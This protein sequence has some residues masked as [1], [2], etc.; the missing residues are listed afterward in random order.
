MSAQTAKKKRL[1]SRRR[2]ANQKETSKAHELHGTGS[3]SVAECQMLE[4]DNESLTALSNPDDPQP[5]TKYP[6]LPELMNRKLGSRRKN[7]GQHVDDSEFHET[8]EEVVKN[9]VG[10]EGQSEK[11][12]ELSKRDGHDISATHSSL[13]ITR[14]HS[15]AVQK[16]ITANTA[17]EVLEKIMSHQNSD[18]SESQQLFRVCPATE[19][20]MDEDTEPLG[21]DGT[22]QRN[23]AMSEPHIQV[24]VKGISTT[25]A[26]TTDETTTECIIEEPTEELPAHVN[27]NEL[28]SQQFDSQAHN[29]SFKIENT[30]N[31]NF[32]FS[33]NRRKLGS[34]RNKEQ[35]H[36]QDSVSESY[37]TKE[38][39]AR[40]VSNNAIETTIPLLLESENDEER[41]ADTDLLKR[42]G[43]LQAN[44]SE[45]DKSKEL[46]REDISYAAAFPTMPLAL[47]VR[48]QEDRE[49]DVFMS[50]TFDHNLKTAYNYS[51][52]FQ[53]L[54]RKTRTDELDGLHQKSIDDPASM[55]ELSDP[56]DEQD[57]SPLKESNMETSDQTN[58][59]DHLNDTETLQT[60]DTGRANTGLDQ[61]Y[62]N[63]AQ[64][65]H[66]IKPT[67]EQTD[68]W[69]K[70]GLL[71]EIEESKS[72]QTLPSETDAPSDSDLQDGS[73]KTEEQNDSN[74]KPLGNR[75]KLGSS[76]RNKGRQHVKGSVAESENTQDNK[77]L[78]TT[79]MALTTDEAVQETSMEIRPEGEV[80]FDHSQTEVSDQDK[81][82]VRDPELTTIS[83]Y[84][85]VEVDQQ[86]INKPNRTQTPDEELTTAF[87]GMDTEN[88]EPDE[89]TDLSRHANNEVPQL[90][91][92]SEGIECSI[93]QE[94]STERSSH[95]QNTD[96]EDRVDQ[97]TV[98]PPKEES[99]TNEEQNDHFR[100]SDVRGAQLSED[101]VKKVLEEEDIKQTK[102]QEIHLGYSPESGMHGAIEDT[103]I[104]S[105][106]LADQEVSDPHKSE[107]IQKSIDDPAS[108]QELSD[109]DDEQDEPPLKESNMETSDQTNE[110]DHVNDT[111]TLQTSDTGRAN[112]GLDQVYENE[113]QAEH[114]I[115]PTSEQT[116]HW[117]KEGLLSEI[118]ESKSA[119]TLPSETDAPS[120]SDL[121]DG[122]VKTE[123]QNDSNFKP[124]GNRRKLGSSRR[125][126][127]RQHVKGSVAESLHK[128]AEEDVEDRANEAP[129]T[130]RS[131]AT[132]QEDSEHDGITSVTYDHS[133]NPESAS[134][135]SSEDQNLM[136]SSPEEELQSFLPKSEYLEESYKERDPSFNVETSDKSMEA[137]LIENNKSDTL[138]DDSVNEVQEQEV[139]PTQIL[140][141]PKSDD[142]FE[143]I[144]HDTG[145]NS[146]TWT[147]NLKEQDEVSDTYQPEIVQKSI[148]DPASMQELS[149]P[150]DEQDESPL[151]ESNM[152]TSDQTNVDDHLNDT[153]TLQTS[154]TGRANTG[155][156]QVYENE[157]QAEHE[158]KPTSEQTDH[159]E[160]EGLLS[161]IEESKSAQTLPSETDAPSD[162]DLQD[163]SVKTEEQNDSN[164]KPLGNRRKLG[165]SRRNKGRQ[166]VKGSVAESLHKSAEEDVEDRA[167]EAPQ[168]TRSS[169]T[170]QEDSE[171]DG[172]TSVTYDHSLNPESAS[173]Y[174]SEDQNLMTSSPEEELQSFLP[175]SEYLEESYKERDPSFNVET[176][177]K[178]MEA[179][180]IENN[181]SDTL[182]DDSVNEVQEQE[183]QPTQILKMPKSDDSFE[184]I[185]HDTGDN[186]DTW[187]RNLKEQD[188]V[189]DTYQ[190]EIVQ[191]SIDDP[192]SM[193]E[194]SDPDDEQDESPL[195]ES[196]M[197][198]SD[199]TNVDDHLNDTETLQTSD[200]GRANTGLDQVYENEAQAEHEIKLTS[201][202]TDHWEKEGLLSEIEESKSAQTLPSETDAPSDSDLQDGS[203]KTEEQNDSNFKPLGNRRKLGSS[204]RNKGR[205]HVKGSVAESLH[206]SAEED[207][208]DRANEAPQTT[209]SSATGQEDS[210]HDGITSVTYDH[211][212]NP[213]SASN[214]SSEDQNLMTSSPEEELQSFLP[215]SEYLEESYKERDPSFN[216]ETS[217]KSME[218]TLKENN[219]SDTLSDDSVNEVQEQE[220]QPTQILKMPKSD[221]SF[222][223]IIHDTGDNSDTWTRN[224]KEQDEVSDTYQPEIVQKSI[225]DPASMQE[226]SDPNDEQDESPLKES[227]M[228]TSDQTNEDDHLN[229]TETLQTSDTERANTGLDQVYEN[230]A[231]AEHEI[232]PTSEQTDHWE[233][234]G[235][236]SEIEESKSAQ[237]LPSET[238]APSDSDL[239]DGS[240]KTEEQNDS[241][242]K[243]LGN[244]RKLGSSRRNKGR[245]HVKGSVAESENT[246]DNKLLGTTK[247]ALTTDEAV[248]ETSME[249][250]Q[251]GEDRF[252]LSQTEVSDQDKTN[253]R[254][255][256]LTTISL[257][258]SVEVDQQVINKPNRTQTPDEELTTAFS[259]M[260]TENK[261]PDENTDLS[262]HA[263]NEVPQLNLK[264]EGIE[265]SITQE[266]STERSSHGQNTDPEDRVDQTTVFPPKEESFTNEEQNDHFRLSDVRGAQLSE[267]AVKKVLEEEDIKQTKLQEIHLGYSPE[268]GMHGAIEDTEI[269][270]ANL[271][272][273]EVSDPHKSETIQKS[274]DD[275]ASMQELSDPDDEQDEPPLK[276]SNM[277]TSDQTNVDDHV[278]DTE[279]LQTSDTGRAN[280]GLDQVYENEAQAEHEIKPTSEQTDHWEKEGLLSE[281]EE[282]KSAQTLPSETDAP[283]DSDLQD[284]SVKTEE[285]N[286]SNFKPLGNRR[287]LGSSRR[288]KGRQHV[289]GSVAE[290]LHKS[291][292]EDVE[293]RAN[294]APQTTRSSATGQEDS[295][296]DG[297][298]SVTYDHSL[299]P[300]SASNYSSEDQNL[301]TS[302]PE[303]ELE[304]FLPKSEY[305]EESYKERDPSFNVETSDKSMEATL[306]ENN[307]SDTLSDDSVNEVQEQEV[308]PTQILKMP[309]SDDSFESIIHDTGDNSDTWTRNLKEQDEV[310][311]TYQP[312]IVQKSID[313]PASMQE[314]SDPDDGLDQVYE[315]E[316]QAEHEIKPTSEQT[317]H[318]EKEGLLSEIEESKSA[319]TLPSETDAP[320]DSDLQDG[321]VKTEEQNDSNFKPLGNR[322]KLGSSRRNKGR[323]HVKGSVAE[324]ENTQDNKLLG[325]TKM[326]LTTDEA[327]QETSM[328]FRQEGEDRFDHSQTE[329]SDQDKTNV[330]DPE[331]TTI[332][333][334]SSVEVDQQVIN[335]PNRT[336]TPDEELTTAF[337]GMDTE[338]KEPD[339]N[340]DLSRHANNEVPQLNLKSEGIECSITQ[341]LSTERSRHG[342]NTDPEDRVDQTT[343]FPPKEESFTNEEQN[344]H[345][346]LSD[347]RGA[348]LSEDAVKKVLEEEDIK[349]TKLQEIH[350]GYSPESG[351]HGAI[352]DTEIC[353]ANLADQEVSDPHKSETIQKSIDD[354]ASMQELSDPDDEQDEPP[355]KESNMETSDQTNVDDHVNDTETLQTSDTGRANTGLDQVYENEAQ[356]EHE[357]KPTSEQTDHWEKEGL[358]SEIEESKSAQTLPSETDA[359]SDSDLQDGSVKTEEQ[360][361]SNFKPLGNRRKLGSSRRNKG[362]Q[363]VKGSVAESL[364]KSAEEDVEDRA[365]EAPQTTRSSATGQEDSEHDGITSVTYDHSLNPESASN[366]SSE[367]Q[368][369]MTS[370]PEEELE[371]FLPKSEYLEESYKERDPSFNVET[372][373]KSMEA[374]LKE[375][376]K[377][378]TL[379]DD[380]V[381]EVQEQEVQPT[382]ILKMPKSDDSFESIIHDTGDNSDTWTRN[383]K[384]QDEVSDT[385]QP[386]IVQKSIDDP[387]SM[388]ELSDPDDEQDESPLKESNM[389]TSDQTNE[390]DHLNDTETLQTSDT[391]RA[392][393]GLDQVYENEAQAEHEI[394]PTSEQTDHW[395]KE[396]LLSEIE[397]SKSA[398]TLPS[399]TDAPSD[400]D[401]QDGSVKTEEQNDSNFKPL[402]NR[403]KLG[404]SRRNK[405]RQHVKGSVA[406][407][408]NTQDNKLLGTTKMAL[409]TDEAVQETSMEFRQEGE[410]RFDHSQTEVSDQDKTNVRD[411]ELTTI[412]LYSSVEVDQQVI[413]KPNRTQT[414]D[415]ELTTAFSGMDTENKEPD[416]NT[417]LSRHAN[418]EVPQLNL[419]SEGI[420]CSI[421]QELSTERSRHGQNTDPEDRVDQTTVFP[422]K[423]E[424]FTNEEQNDHFRLSDVRGAQLSEDAV[425]KV[426]EEEDIKQ[427][428][429]QEIHLGYS[430]ESGMHGAIEDTEI[431]SANLADQE[432]SDPHKS[433][434]IQKSIDDP[435]SM[436]ELSDP[437]D[438]QDEPP[439]KESNME[440]S[441]QTNVDDH[442]NDTETLQ[443]SD[444]GRA[445][446]GLDQV[447]ENEAQAEHEIKPT[448]EQ[449]DHWEKEGLLSEIEESKSAQTLPS[450]TDAP[451][452]SDLQDGSVK[453]EE[454]N[455]SN[456]KPLGNRRK[457]GSSRR[458]KGRQHVKGSVAESLHKSAEEDVEDRAN[459]A[460]QTTRSSA[461]G[462]EDSEHDGI[463]SVTYDHSLNPESASN[464]SSEDQ[465]LMTSSPEEELESFLP[466][467]EYLEESYKERDPSFNVETSDKSM[468]ATLKENNKSD[469]LSDD[470]VNEVQEQEVQPTQILK[471]PKSDDSFESIIHDT[472]DNSDTWTRNLKEQD[473]VSD[474]YQPEIVQKSIDDPA[475]MQ[476]LSDPDDEQ[477]ESPLKESNME[478]SDQ[479]NEDD[480]LNDTETLQT[481]DTG[482]ANTGL[483]QVYENEAQ[484]EHEIKPTSEQTDHW[485]KEGLLSEIEESKSAQTL[486]SETDAPS[487]SD[488]QDGSVKTEEQNDSNFK[489]LGNRR[490]LGSSRRN[491]GRQ[492]VKGSVAESENTQ[493]NKLLGTTKMALTTDE[494][495]QETSMEFRQEGEDRFDHSQT[496][497]SDQ[498]KTN[499][500]DPEL[501]T[502][503]LYSSVEV[504]QQVINKPNRT[505]TPDE[506][507]TTAFSGMDT[508]NKEPDENTDL[509]RHANNEVPQLNLKSE[510]IECSI[511]QELSTERSSHGQN[512]DPEDRVD[513]TTVFPP[514]EESFTNEEQ[515][516]HFRLSDVRGAQL[517]EDAVK[518]V[519]EEEDIKQTKLQEIHLGYSP[520]SGMHG[521]IEDTEICSA[522]L[523]DQEVSDPHKSET[524]QKSI[525]DPASMQELSDP[526]DEQDEPPLKE[527]NMETSDQTNVDD[528][529]N[530][531]ETL[532]TSDTG[533]ANTGLDQVYENEAQAEHEI[534]PTSEQT[535]HWEK[536]GLLSE[537]EE[538]KSAQT[539]PSETDAPSDSDLQDGSVKTEEQN[540]SNFKPLGNRRKLGSSRRNKGRQNIKDSSTLEKAVEETSAETL[541]E[542]KETSD[543]PQTVADHG[544]LKDDGHVSTFDSTSNKEIIDKF[545]VMEVHDQDFSSV[546]SV[547]DTE[548][549][550][551]GESVLKRSA[552]LQPNNLV[553]GSH[554]KLESRESSTTPAQT[555]EKSRQH[556]ECGLDVEQSAVSLPKEEVSANEK[557][558][559]H[560]NPFEVR[561][562]QQSEDTLPEEKELKLREM[563]K[564]HEFDHSSIEESSHHLPTLPLE[565]RSPQDCQSMDDSES[566]KEGAHSGFKFTGSRRKL[567]SSRRNRGR[568]HS[569]HPEHPEELVENTW[570]DKTPL[571]TETTGQRGS[572]ER[573]E[574]GFT[575]S[576]K[577]KTA[578]ADIIDSSTMLTTGISLNSDKIELPKFTQDLSGEKREHIIDGENLMSFTGYDTA[579][580]DLIQSE[581]V[582]AESAPDVHG[583]EQVKVSEE[584]EDRT[585]KDQAGQETSTSNEVIHAQ[586]FSAALNKMGMWAFDVGVEENL[587]RNQIVNVPGESEISPAAAASH[588]QQVIEE[589]NTEDNCENLQENVNKKKRKIGS[590]R[591]SQL[592]RKQEGQTD[593]QGQTIE[594][595][596]SEE[597]DMRWMEQVKEVTQNENT[598]PSLITVHREQ[599]SSSPSDLQTVETNIKPRIDD[600]VV[601]HTD[602]RDTEGTEDHGAEP[603]KPNDQASTEMETASV[604]SRRNRRSID[605]QFLSPNP[606]DT[607]NPDSANTL[608]FS[609]ATQNT[610]TEEQSPETPS[611]ALTGGKA[612]EGDRGGQVSEQEPNNMNEG[613]NNKTSEKRNAS[614]NFSSTSRRKK[615]SSTRRKLV[616]PSKGEDL[617][618]EQEGD[619]EATVTSVGEALTECVSRIEDEKLQLHN[620]EEGADSEQRKE[621]VFETTECIYIGESQ[622]NPTDALREL[623]EIEHHPAVDALP[624]TPSTSPK[625]DVMAEADAGRRRRKL[626]SH[627]KSHGHQPLLD[628]LSE[629]DQSNQKSSSTISISKAIE[630]KRPKS[631]GGADGVSPVQTPHCDI[632]LVPESQEKFSFGAH[633]S[634]KTYNVL[635]VGDSSVGKT[636][637]MKRAQSGKFSLDLPASVGL[638][639]CMWTVVVD[640]KPVVL[641]LWDTAGQERFHSMT[642]QIFHK[643]QAFLLMYDITSSQSFTAVSY[644]ANCIQ[645]GAP[646]DVSILLLGNKSDHPTRQVK[647]Q[648]GETLAKEYSFE[649][650][651][652]SA[653]TGENVIQSLE[654]VARMLSQKDGTTEEVTVLHK[655]PPQKKSSGCC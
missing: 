470:S 558:N 167:N 468:E 316:A 320:S 254:D 246:Q 541:V 341:E 73:V 358:L 549:K 304:S 7:E 324:S 19:K 77:L 334:Y 152:E 406:E 300:E 337:S 262:R 161:E 575:C 331:L 103:E 156:D 372:S 51:S 260:D 208:E 222:E 526:D 476:E 424:S 237:T 505:Q 278:N 447:Y 233:K 110:D 25:A 605:F 269:C 399:E 115:K 256:E 474:T 484:A 296:H 169:A 440:T 360:N 634:S 47:Q 107:T 395:E 223:S 508:E 437:D 206:K 122:S 66:E 230:E 303:E 26:I 100:L 54:T 93:T 519:L 367:D 295:E 213:E 172:I 340:T 481:S 174:S 394:K 409:T 158:I 238:D 318:W 21:E 459:E 265:C 418:N 18:C 74:F 637:F 553:D 201:E 517:S 282:S 204:R 56:N 344:D 454:Q 339:E 217:D 78:G 386:E 583:S 75:R 135:Y 610:Q 83:L 299:N 408:E 427:T 203:V 355:L 651:E 127:G 365:N 623:A 398:Q 287:K 322:R 633:A 179:T 378:D 113:A 311:D 35:Q 149:D 478:T 565:V 310:S 446:T 450:E 411:P 349:Q 498:D 439:L 137:T 33:V 67:S 642:R 302:S 393:T 388:Q 258:S 564:M 551:K 22:L 253:V 31:T 359:P 420:E 554:L 371:S 41:Q 566:I 561:V 485:E 473:E 442:V 491:K 500:R 5:D 1:G 57:E 644:W 241:N 146:D 97:T 492:H 309:K 185:I 357:I 628:K 596:F 20:E 58:V 590:T 445:N 413:N 507:L 91:L 557:Q 209:R 653:A 242:F 178:S 348:Q 419:K 80:K 109:P 373:D 148:D 453:T 586:P 627:R 547:T 621:K 591:K 380:S 82:N 271:A 471:M 48:S 647:S 412:S 123:E 608:S 249:F 273:Q 192:A 145:D 61:V 496:E 39:V 464:Y 375:N 629:V 307:K 112:T 3:A 131:S 458:N 584:S 625:E 133:L 44:V 397:E 635:M 94:L 292:E 188:E 219:K 645:E 215:K 211:S 366:Y 81:T 126:K 138:S 101:A 326:A 654:T 495:V 197:E 603:L 105:A 141:M 392:N 68:H 382:Q 574:P 540:D 499:V 414:P 205:Q 12:E 582:S 428:K 631:E 226:L 612:G 236:L 332:S 523:A 579:K 301:M 336:Q 617:H 79:K 457:L 630:H 529:V 444:T 387:A 157:A 140:K 550:E 432:V 422:P 34:R 461:T 200:T 220:V 312:E 224:H 622:L 351:M 563:Q 64:A 333:L 121:Q 120:D 537:I 252:D 176:S 578:P 509:S 261:E 207:V 641:K 106:N 606:V 368:N 469:T 535:D 118:E 615:L 125:N 315:N 346:R 518:K 65:E 619:N 147:R 62:E 618:Q 587:R 9:T 2:G 381:N 168:T 104:C 443:T 639:S 49:H 111:E 648:E 144:I 524:I 431:C 180:L 490:K 640:G 580:V 136:T 343:V 194:L 632:R 95:G 155:L 448:S 42:W 285:Q 510:G 150:D 330:R 84:S 374:T 151:K 456:F 228:E 449:T 624:G 190:P 130:T 548:S 609:E 405:G 335:K 585:N 329:V 163:G 435:A 276:E 291:A 494:A 15:C 166:H 32:N 513:Q 162:S 308:Q 314:L 607:I 221:D 597:A 511:T 417:D 99:F 293:D 186:S 400:S 37:E 71:S 342:Q 402:G 317:D 436:Q 555:T 361:D 280:T 430:P 268:S 63:E 377:S 298:T 272:D 96:P 45:S 284:G 352:E 576:E 196:N 286:D 46:D 139:Q 599:E 643:A 72:A 264:S 462:Q 396:G 514:K 362:R 199:Q 297:I 214:Y 69:E 170:G 10:K 52:D 426:L 116:D 23:Y 270:S 472:G 463:T 183:V 560:F 124:L 164:F 182:S 433:E 538:S 171:H 153:E 55:Q 489:P 593:I 531:T 649:F 143:S 466:K 483:D 159:W 594:T 536:E 636:S 626:G 556:T 117:E 487:D 522:N 160:K 592:K 604:V 595:K 305:L 521:A 274:I 616:S 86:V 98:F 232:K 177:D 70:E 559:S 244:R 376:N 534:K 210:E 369:L 306:K 247:M 455:D 533:R 90:N 527:S 38:G 581:E 279:T 128:S 390:D 239:Q 108:M 8:R 611:A 28:I 173:N 257:Y 568:Q 142:S 539:L 385:Y 29:L 429:L 600:S 195:K 614:P 546:S 438:E 552:I 598:H 646:D 525:D 403:R 229:D 202:Q 4:G 503:S 416:E 562:A 479:T 325:T 516:D 43:F 571:G 240:V 184:S 588:S 347:V 259:G 434:T 502:I 567:G 506:E 460:P 391:G 53:N 465:N 313:D 193:Q 17:A 423:E 250:R 493:D 601:L 227:N 569:P 187:T 652:C 321:S 501:T 545:C 114:E 175:K 338:N 218:A 255:P 294:E 441:D 289:K 350:L 266:L 638:D 543:P 102:L 288:N 263:N 542:R 85:S 451:S 6:P 480:H 27:Q 613:A 497:V 92:K 154:D 573:T 231:Q 528:H 89:N 235:L 60:S 14:D 452:D 354:P 515:N 181:K 13:A 532:Q 482:R 415:E 345:F 370:S 655:E 283:S 40:K 212:L 24:V 407:S 356:A 401:L 243:P 570:D 189:S 544:K 572:K 251:E 275:P 76:R 134:N 191:K 467:S 602:V 389:E 530:D 245:Q 248:Q 281:I 650:M 475:S 234:E 384:E 425:K 620:E 50:V 486:P 216:V 319:Q 129:Q 363:H 16:T 488:L 404:S 225:D 504:D 36:I 364:H 59:D 353:S 379:S 88:K 267:D 290:S 132:G 410:D 198:T 11:E 589:R 119:Q 30:T 577:T 520:E 277:E 165:S 87:S 327:V 477:D 421:T 323:Q 512:T 328:E 383:L